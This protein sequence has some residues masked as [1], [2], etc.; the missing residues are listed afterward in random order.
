MVESQMKKVSQITI[1][2]NTKIPPFLFS[3]AT[4]FLTKAEAKEEGIL[5][6]D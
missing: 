1:N 2:L 5:Y 3:K 4:I 6:K